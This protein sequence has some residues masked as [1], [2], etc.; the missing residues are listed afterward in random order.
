MTLEDWRDMMLSETGKELNLKMLDDTFDEMVLE[1]FHETG[2]ESW[3]RML[4]N[5]TVIESLVDEY[6]TPQFREEL[7]A[8]VEEYIGADKCSIMDADIY[9]D[10]YRDC[11]KSLLE[12]Y[13]ETIGLDEMILNLHE[14]GESP[15]VLIVNIP[16]VDVLVLNWHEEYY[17]N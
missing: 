15:L 8:L 13:C 11:F 9:N 3:L 10:A 6:Y 2:N 7:A 12:E 1:M 4:D 17:Q 16:D 5:E 14:Y